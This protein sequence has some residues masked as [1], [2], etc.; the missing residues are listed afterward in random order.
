MKVI[1]VGPSLS[2]PDRH[3]A[4]CTILPPAAQGDIARAVL[5]GAS[6][7]GL[8]DGVYET[9]AAVWHKE[10]LFAIER[11]VR[12]LGAASMGALRAAECAAFGMEPVGE[13]ANR[14]LDGTL[15]DDA[16]VAVLHAPREMDYLQLSEALVDAEATIAHLHDLQRISA[17][18]RRALEGSAAALFFKER[19]AKSIV[20]GARGVA[21]GRRPE[22]LAAYQSHRISL[23]QQDAL[24]LMRRMATIRPKKPVLSP[25]WTLS[26]PESWR[27]LMADLN[28]GGQ[29]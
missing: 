6:A 20:S 24:L 4:G 21:A 29:I 7:V 5:A 15:D 23:K 14:Y 12:M 19:T 13:I 27:H 11:G 18:E 25:A 16:A 26:Q 1:F 2:P 17:A 9:V 22:L 3:A 8:I 10:I 28:P